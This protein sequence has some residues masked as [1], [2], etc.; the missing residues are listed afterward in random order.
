MTTLHTAHAP[1][2]PVS[3]RGVDAYSQPHL[4]ADK[5]RAAAAALARAAGPAMIADQA[6][7]GRSSADLL[8]PAPADVLPSVLLLLRPSPAASAPVW[9]PAPCAGAPRT[10][11]RSLV[12]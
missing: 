6:W 10:R 5:W 4:R 7:N 9:L 1:A 2:V 3:S 12:P 8:S 11:Y